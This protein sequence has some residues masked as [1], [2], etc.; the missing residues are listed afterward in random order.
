MKDEIHVQLL[1]HPD[2][3]GLGG[4]LLNHAT[5]QTDHPLFL[6]QLYSTD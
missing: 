6:F 1:E 2:R 4:G 3:N 5:D